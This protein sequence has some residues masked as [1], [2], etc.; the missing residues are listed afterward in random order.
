MVEMDILSLENISVSWRHSAFT[1]LICWRDRYYCGFREG[2]EH[3]SY[4]GR[5]VIRA[6]DDLI[7]WEPAAVLEGAFPD[8]RDPKFLATGDEL[9]VHGPAWAHPGPDDIQ[10]HGDYL[11]T[12]I[13]S[14]SDGSLWTDPQPTHE[15]VC[16]LW[17]PITVD[18]IHHVA[19]HHRLGGKEDNALRWVSLA[20]STD[21]RTWE[22][23]SDIWREDGANETQVFALDNGRL[24]ALVRCARKSEGSAVAVANML[25]VASPP[26]ETWECT[27]LPHLIHGPAVCKLGN[28]YIAGGRTYG[29]PYSDSVPHAAQMVLFEL[30]VENGTSRTIATL[31]SWGDCSYP[32][33]L[34]LSDTELGISYYSSHEGATQVYIARVALVWD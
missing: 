27:R 21:G 28:R 24:G 34:A 5:I 16:V 10:R 17:R 25:A 3:R 12:Y 26:Y 8:L 22:H 11:R 9:I 18:G 4:R 14:T 6:S 23:V 15:P 32:A 20:R 19:T 13:S 2:D 1:D 7:Q 29:E 31:P 33:M 30:D